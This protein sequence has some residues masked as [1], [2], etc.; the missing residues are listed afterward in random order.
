MAGQYNSKKKLLLIMDYLMK[1]SDEDNPVSTGELIEMLKRNGIVCERKS[2]YSDIEAL[3]DFG[4]DIVKTRL[5]KGGYFIASRQFE[6]VEIR[7]LI[8]AVQSAS[9]IT[10]GKSKKL[11]KNIAS[12]CSEEQMKK[13]S[14]RVYIDNRVKSDNETIYYSIDEIGRAI[15]SGRQIECDYAK[16]RTVSKLKNGA[17]VEKHL[18]L[19]PYAMIW[20]A[21]HY[22][23]VANNPKYDNLMHLRID[24]MRNVS[25]VEGSAVRPFSEVSDYTD[26]FDVADY[27]R[28]IFNM[29]S[30]ETE[31]IELHC[32]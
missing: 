7:L 10:P 28:R 9:F 8:D 22:Y 16:C 6:E 30:G 29:Y 21:D 24:R 11:I 15:D 20:S 4:F 19:N 23:L 13:L 5:G 32:R 1:Y 26:F 18:K 3:S 14:S 27:S 2:V 17:C 31:D 25:I 12:L